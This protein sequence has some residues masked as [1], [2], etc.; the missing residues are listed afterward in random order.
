MQQLAVK[1]TIPDAEAELERKVN[2][3]LDGGE[4]E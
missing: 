3:V 1:K 2:R 4:W